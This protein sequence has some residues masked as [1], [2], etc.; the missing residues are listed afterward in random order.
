MAVEEVSGEPLSGFNS[1]L[2]G[3]NTGK[4][5]NSA[6]KSAGINLYGAEFT[7]VPG[8][9]LRFLSRA[10]QGMITH[11]SG[12]SISL[13]IVDDETSAS[14]SMPFRHLDSRMRLRCRRHFCLNRQNPF[15]PAPPILRLGR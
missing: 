10:E 14:L 1:L 7:P 2:T 4:F 12:N 6:R 15:R 3:E 9:G 5:A 13:I 11:T 8:N